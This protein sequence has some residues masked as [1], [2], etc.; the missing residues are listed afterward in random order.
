VNGYLF[1][2]SGDCVHHLNI[3]RNKSAA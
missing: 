1:D 2:E 3:N